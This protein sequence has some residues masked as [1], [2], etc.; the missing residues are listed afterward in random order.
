MLTYRTIQEYPRY[1]VVDVYKG[2]EKLYRTT[3]DKKLPTDAE[4][5]QLCQ[6]LDVPIVVTA[7]EKE[8]NTK[9]S[10][11]KFTEDTYKAVKESL[12]NKANT[13]QAICK[14]HKISLKTLKKIKD[15]PLHEFVI[16]KKYYQPD[17]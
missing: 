14:M 17:N 4:N 8:G 3:K 12:T 7:E 15:T 13:Q 9:P 2:N 1:Y 5:Y 11:I 10:R 16:N 6:K